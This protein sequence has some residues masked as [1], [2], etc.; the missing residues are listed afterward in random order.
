MHKFG[1]N[2]TPLQA[3]ERQLRQLSRTEH[4]LIEAKQERINALTAAVARGGGGGRGGGGVPRISTTHA[5]RFVYDAKKDRALQ[6]MALNP[7]L[8]SKP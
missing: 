3:Q 6:V 2:V 5:H 8:S 4:R 1:H 7:K